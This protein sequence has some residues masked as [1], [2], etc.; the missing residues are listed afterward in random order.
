M[1]E[2]DML[3]RRLR[4]EIDATFA[5]AQM[6]LELDGEADRDI[7]HNS[8]VTAYVLAFHTYGI[9]YEGTA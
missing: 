2:L 9:S 4:H 1:H 8:D 5:L 6:H 3:R 7:I